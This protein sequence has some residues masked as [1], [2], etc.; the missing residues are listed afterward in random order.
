MTTAITSAM[1]DSS[2][3]AG[4][5]PSTRPSTGWRVV[6]EVPKSPCSTP[7]PQIRNCCGIDLSS[8]YKRGQPGDVGL[9]RAGRQHH[10]DG[11][12]GHHADHHE[13]DHRHAEQSDGGGQKPGQNGADEACMM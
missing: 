1:I 8:P 5:R 13:D 9:G 11:V 6:I 3:V 10:G 12:S 4:R 7:A 2:S